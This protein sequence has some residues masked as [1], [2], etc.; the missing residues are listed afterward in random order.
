MNKIAHINS[1]LDLAEGQE[2]GVS[3]WLTID[4]D[5]ITRFGH[6]T[7][8]IDPLHLDPEWAKANGPFGG[9]T[10]YGFLTMSMLS[11]L[12]RD[13]LE[14]DLRSVDMG[15]FLN[16]GFEKLRLITPVKVNSRI[17]GRFASGGVR[18]DKGGRRIKTI[19]ATVEIEGE[20]RPA[21]VAEWLS[22]W[23]PPAPGGGTAITG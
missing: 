11:Y 1:L 12:L 22:A 14:K 5:M 15:L 20:D 4:Q 18:E 3:D 10:A 8:D 17:R 7:R 23:V 6:L 13:M 9:T 16:Y 2:I 21:L 19:L